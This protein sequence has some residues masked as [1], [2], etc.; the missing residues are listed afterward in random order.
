MVK[1]IHFSYVFGGRNT[2]TSW[3]TGHC[4]QRKG[5]PLFIPLYLK[6]I[7]GMSGCRCHS[8]NVFSPSEFIGG[9][10]KPQ[11]VGIRK[12]GLWE[13]I[14]SWGGAHMNEIS[15]LLKK[16]IQRAPI[17]CPSCK[18]IEDKLERRFSPDTKSAGI[19]LSDSPATRTV[20]KKCLLLKLPGLWYFYYSSLNGLK[21]CKRREAIHYTWPLKRVGAS[22][23]WKIFHF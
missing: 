5:Y 17:P 1:R 22:Y 19:L 12:W 16:K 8:L 4:G 11:C 2:R 6:H 14:K 23:S 10:P 20:S 9:N 3:S 15:A 7:R 18:N 13:L 21:L